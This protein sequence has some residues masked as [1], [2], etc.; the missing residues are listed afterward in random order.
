M[1]QITYF[2]LGATVKNYN[3]NAIEY[4]TNQITNGFI[5]NTATLLG[6]PFISTAIAGAE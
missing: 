4:I 5:S 3:N 6:M 2:N 1:S